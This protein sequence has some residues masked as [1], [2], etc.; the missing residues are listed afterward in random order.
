MCVL[1]SR[2][3]WGWVGRGPRET[4]PTPVV[5]RPES[6]RSC[7]SEEEG[8]RGGSEARAPTPL[9]SPSGR[10]RERAGKGEN[11]SSETEGCVKESLYGSGGRRTVGPRSLQQGSGLHRGRRLSL[12]AREED[13]PRV[14]PGRARECGSPART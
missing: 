1:L 7:E 3:V 5:R 13:R 8:G 6:A 12:G 2:S 10:R 14:G 4:N 11:P 9:P